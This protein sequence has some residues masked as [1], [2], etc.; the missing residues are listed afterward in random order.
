M[1]RRSR[2]KAKGQE[3]RVHACRV[4]VTPP[5]SATGPCE[6]SSGRTSKLALLSPGCS[7]CFWTHFPF[8]SIGERADSRSKS[9]GSD[10]S[11]W[12]LV[13]SGHDHQDPTGIKF[14]LASPVS[15][16]PRQ[17]FS[18]DTRRPRQ[19]VESASRGILQSSLGRRAHHRQ[20]QRVATLLQA[21]PSAARRHCGAAADLGFVS[22]KAAVSLLLSYRCFAAG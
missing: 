18:D 15:S 5:H 22:G 20:G 8:L 19:T 16:D 12:V 7:L 4:T 1:G 10:W 6:N 14:P 3:Q 21:P 13:S 9:Q 11:E 17:P 2:S